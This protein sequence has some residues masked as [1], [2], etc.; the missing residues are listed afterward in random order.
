[1]QNNITTLCNSE[2]MEKPY[3]KFQLVSI[4]R[5]S[6]Q[7]WHPWKSHKPTWKWSTSQ[8]CKSDQLHT[9]KLKTLTFDVLGGLGTLQP[10][11]QEDEDLPHVLW[12]QTPATQ[13]PRSHGT[14]PAYTYSFHSEPPLV[15]D[16]QH[17]LWHQATATQHHIFQWDR[18][19]AHIYLSTVDQ[20]WKTCHLYHDTRPLQSNT[21]TRYR[22][23]IHIHL[24]PVDHHWWK[25]C[26][27]YC[28]TRLLQHTP[29]VHMV[30]SQSTHTALCRGT[31]NDG[32]S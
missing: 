5:T 1:M 4:V 7:L 29:H 3:G 18:A 31:T 20:Y 8:H 9:R 21:F 14:E 30:C 25:T 15:K 23:S 13:Q 28:N 17:V 26:C 32:P 27:M 16:L 12:H 24:S 6:L 2:S 19:N 22:T 10:L 11:E